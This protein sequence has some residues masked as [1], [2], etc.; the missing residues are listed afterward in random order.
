MVNFEGDYIFGEKQQEIIKPILEKTF[1]SLI[2]NDRYSKYDF[3]NDNYYI[4]VKTRKNSYYTYP[5]TLLTC[6]KITNTDKTLIF[7]F[8]FTDGIYYI[9]Y[10]EK[11]FNCFEKKMFSRINKK[12]D[13]KDYYYIPI[14]MLKKI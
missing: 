8:N 2:S 9:E 1:G 13:M 10:D 3:E 7:I 14:D 4:E 11:I 6:N 5:T 12:F